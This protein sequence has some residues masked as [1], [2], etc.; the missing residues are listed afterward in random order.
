MSELGYSSA[1]CKFDKRAPY[2]GKMKIEFIREKYGS[3]NYP[4]FIGVDTIERTNKLY[5]MN[6]MSLLQKKGSH[7]T[8]LFS[9]S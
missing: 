3:T 1:R 5:R 8:F 9:A 2:K 4:I 6:W 7:K